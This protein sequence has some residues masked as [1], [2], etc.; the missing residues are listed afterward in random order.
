MNAENTP[1]EQLCKEVFQDVGKAVQALREYRRLSL[2]DA[3]TRM[4]ITDKKLNAI[5]RGILY[6]NINSLCR[7]VEALGG[8][9]VIVPAEKEN[10]PHCKFI[11]VEY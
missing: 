7:L 8:R 10:D 9:L 2:V 3:A 6:N 11:E 5:E 1:K 4:E